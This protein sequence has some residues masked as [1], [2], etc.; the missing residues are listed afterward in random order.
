MFRLAAADEKTVAEAMKQHNRD[1]KILTD[2]FLAGK[3]FIGK[4]W[5]NVTQ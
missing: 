3:P 2:Y 1:K 5:T 4:F